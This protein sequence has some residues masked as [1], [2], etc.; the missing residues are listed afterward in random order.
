MDCMYRRFLCGVLY[1]RTGS[2]CVSGLP[3][4]H[5]SSI[6]MVMSLAGLFL[7]DWYHQKLGMRIGI[8][9]AVLASATGMFLYAGAGTYVGH[10]IASMTCGIGNGLGSGVAASLLINRWFT[11][12]RAFAIGIVSASTGLASVIAP[13][14]IVPMIEQ[15]S[16]R[17]SFFVEGLFVG[18][19]ALLSFV[20]IRDEDG[21]TEKKSPVAAM[22][23]SHTKFLDLNLLP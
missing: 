15:G 2:K 22:E 19:C 1:G 21:V 12:Q 20:L 4:I 8:S 3:P 7:I 9:L 23:R 18:V 17:F 13:V 5:S 16:L 10:C 11:K 6:C 14:I